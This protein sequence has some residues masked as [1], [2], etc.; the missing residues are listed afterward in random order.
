MN[1]NMVGI[2]LTFKKTANLFS[3][4]TSFCILTNSVFE[5]KLPT[6]VFLVF[7]FSCS[8]GGKVL[9]H[10]GFNLYFSHD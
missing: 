3:V 8:D 10:C 1:N 5:F 9:S 4:V 2:D 7:N 6:L